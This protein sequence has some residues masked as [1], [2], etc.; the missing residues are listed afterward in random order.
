MQL[1]AALKFKSRRLSFRSAL[2]AAFITSILGGVPAASNA[3]TGTLQ[4]ATPERKFLVS[5]FQI[6]GTASRPAALMMS[7]AKGYQADAYLRLAA[8]LNACG[9]DVFLIHYISD[10]D[11]AAMASAG[12]AR[13]RIAYYAQRMADWS[14]TIRSTIDEIR[15]QPRYQSKI[16]L[17]GISL[18]AMPATMVGANNPDIA[19]AAIVDGSFPANFQSRVR[20]IPP[21]MLIWGS[22]DRVFPQSTGTKLADLARALGGSAELLVYRG[23]GHGFFLENGNANATNAHAKI[24]DFFATHLEPRH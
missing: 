17:L 24:V 20:S 12:S 19:A 14:A 2:F 22:E 16:G 5:T 9:I 18:G 23:E 3:Q 13:A 4:L 21:L 6:A 8:A 11:V 7:G 15:R 1:I 10:S